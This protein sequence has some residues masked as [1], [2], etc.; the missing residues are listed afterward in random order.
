MTGALL[1]AT[2]K[3]AVERRKNPHLAIA[4][5]S[6]TPPDL[7]VVQDLRVA[8][9]RSMLEMRDHLLRLSETENRPGWDGLFDTTFKAM[10]ENH[11][12]KYRMASQHTTH[13]NVAGGEDAP[14]L[15]RPAI[16]L[17]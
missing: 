8:W 5:H 7:E 9:C 10:L 3:Q 1:E 6:A 16:E 4:I 2:V 11:R 14:D 13:N 17:F 12:S 15:S